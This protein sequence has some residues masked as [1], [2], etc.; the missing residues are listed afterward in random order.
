MALGRDCVCVLTIR[1]GLQIAFTS[2]SKKLFN[3][4]QTSSPAHC[5]L[6]PNKRQHA[7][8]KKKELEAATKK[9]GQGE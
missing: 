8:T 9:M 7:S 3:C 2:S 6:T 1:E 5:I 4:S